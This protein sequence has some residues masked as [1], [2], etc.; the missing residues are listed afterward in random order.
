MSLAMLHP[1]GNPQH[2]YSPAPAASISFTATTYYPP[3]FPSAS[4]PDVS[5][6][7]SSKRVV[8]S[9]GH[10][11]KQEG[12]VSIILADQKE[13]A[14]VPVYGTKGIVNGMV[15]VHEPGDVRHVELMMEGHVRIREVG[16]GGTT[17][18]QLFTETLVLWDTEDGGWPPVLHYFNRA[19]PTHYTDPETNKKH[20]MP[21]TYYARLTGIPGFSVSIE[22]HLILSVT[23]RS[24]L[25]QR[26]RRIWVPFMYRPRTTASMYPPLPPIPSAS[27]SDPGRVFVGTL[28][29]RD[30]QQLKP[31]TVYLH[32]P[33]SRVCSYAER[34]PF[35]IRLVGPPESLAPFTFR[36]A[37]DG[38][39]HPIGHESPL[40]I[41]SSETRAIKSLRGYISKKLAPRELADLIQVRIDRQT[42]VDARSASALCCDGTEDTHLS[43]TKTIGEGVIRETD[44]SKSWIGCSGRI[45]LTD[46]ECGSFLASRVTVAVCILSDSNLGLLL[47]LVLRTRS[48]SRLPCPEASMAERHFCFTSRPPRYA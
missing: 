23:R 34:V 24:L 20:P 35:Q 38:S 28:M 22:Y 7:P 30:D 40:S 48:W 18:Q 27:P 14:T 44:R 11:S 36:P 4:A 17:E 3:K 45:E 26:T 13:G 19:I 39:I 2:S 6:V 1:Y 5:F 12:K 47:I 31:I 32:L 43:V 16:E 42:F 41:L 15:S 8:K 37:A 10:Y 9:K 33:L 21:P 29:P 46:V 25:R